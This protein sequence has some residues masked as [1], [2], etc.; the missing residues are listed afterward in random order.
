MGVIYLYRLKE[1]N[2]PLYVGKTKHKI[3]KRDYAHKKA[4]DCATRFEK[5]AKEIGWENISLEIIREDI[6]DNKLCWA[7][8][9][10]WDIYKPKYNSICPRRTDEEIIALR[11]LYW[12]RKE[13]EQLEFEC[14]AA[15]K[16]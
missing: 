13:C 10:C 3:S 14:L 2:T 4:T 7:E 15:I 6:E 1:D 5:K 9:E 12:A 11:E 8:R 16:T